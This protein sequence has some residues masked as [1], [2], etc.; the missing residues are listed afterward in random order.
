MSTTQSYQHK[1]TSAARRPQS[2]EEQLTDMRNRKV[3]KSVAADLLG[4]NY[5]KLKRI[6]AEMG[7][8]WPA[9]NQARRIVLDGIEGTYAEHAKRL[10]IKTN[11]LAD[12]YR[13]NGTAR[14][15]PEKM[16][17]PEKVKAFIEH[18]RN[19]LPAW[20]AAAMVGHSYYALD[21]KAKRTCP[22]YKAVVKAAT[23]VRRTK[24]EM[25]SA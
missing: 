18:R 14:P 17:T 3:P 2:L 16:I 4:I 21:A 6:I 15:D 12:R 20:K 19:G 23:R 24:A 8:H 13:R 22:E 9:Q 10:G 1:P 5:P 7:L 25:A 11:T